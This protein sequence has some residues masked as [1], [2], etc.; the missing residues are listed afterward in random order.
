MKCQ[1]DEHQLVCVKCGSKVFSAHV[2]RNCRP[3][4]GDRVASALSA[5]GITKE[6]AQAVA[7]AVGI[8]DCGCAGRQAAL[9]RAG[10]RLGIGTPPPAESGPTG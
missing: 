7:S 9:N 2:I 8:R 10:Y 5:A 4:L 3:G 6:R 1:V